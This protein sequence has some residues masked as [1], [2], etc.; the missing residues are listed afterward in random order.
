MSREKLMY[1]TT[2]E[3]VKEYLLDIDE[4]VEDE[5]LQMQHLVT[6]HDDSI[7]TLEA[8]D[9]EFEGVIRSVIMR[10]EKQ[11]VKIEKRL[12]RLEAMQNRTDSP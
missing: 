3:E 1:A 9:Q 2:L 7:I 8:N 10:L 12:E 4:D 5:F 6:A 11:M